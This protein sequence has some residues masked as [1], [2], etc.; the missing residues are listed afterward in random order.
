VSATGGS[1]NQ[2]A[3]FQAELAKLLLSEK[4]I[5]GLLDIVVNLS[6]SAVAGVQGAS[7]SLVISD[8]DR[9]ETSNASS[10]VIR[11]VDEAQYQHRAGPCVE[12]I[13]T[14]REVR[15]A[16][17]TDR[18]PTFAERAQE[19]GVSSVWSLPLRVRDQTTGALNLYSTGGASVSAAGIEV[20]RALADQAAVVL[21]NAAALAS[22]ELTKQHLEQALT[23]R[24]LIGQAKGILMARQGVS[25]EEAFDLLRRASQASGRK[26]SDIAIEVASN[27]GGDPRD[28]R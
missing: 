23:N 26:L 27:P 19:A 4:T 21:A 13:R 20:A 6:V 5:A 22:A 18:W 1:E 10:Q 3:D 8:G 2:P 17:P 16:L 25:A 12:A 15:I 9:L 24:D 7:I 14:G 11:T 28:R